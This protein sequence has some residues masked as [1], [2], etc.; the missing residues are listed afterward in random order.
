MENVTINARCNVTIDHHTE[1]V[2]EIVF[3]DV[4]TFG[5][6]TVFTEYDALTTLN[7][8]EITVRRGAKVSLENLFLFLAPLDEHQRGGRGAIVM[9]LCQA[10]L[11][12]SVCPSIFKLFIQASSTLNLMV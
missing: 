8:T 10:C 6:L 9:V 3:L 11:H 7:G 12:P 5:T 1:T 2:N 4:K